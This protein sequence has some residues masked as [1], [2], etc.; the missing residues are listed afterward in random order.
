[1]FTSCCFTG[2]GDIVL[3]GCRHPCMEVQDGVSFIANDVYLLRDR[4]SFLIITGPNMGGKSTY[5]RQVGGAG[6]SVVAANQIMMILFYFL[7]YSFTAWSVV[8]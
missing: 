7:C 8:V 1:M 6:G 4:E 3:L 5:M 2:E